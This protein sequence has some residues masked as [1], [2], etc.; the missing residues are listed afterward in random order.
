MKMMNGSYVEELKAVLSGKKV[1]IVGHD[2][3]DVDALLSSILMSRLLT[4]L[5][6]ENE[7][8]ILE[9][10]KKDDTYEIA[11]EMFGI[12]MEKWENVL[13]D[14][15]RTLFLLDHYT[16]I[17]KGTVIGCVDHHPNNA[18]KSYDFMYTRKACAAAYLVYE[19]MEEAGYCITAEEAK[20]IIVSMMVDT[21]AFRSSKTIETEAKKAKVLAEKFSL[22]YEELEKYCLCLTPVESM[23]IDQI[24]SNGQKWYDYSGNKVGS[25]Y[26][27][28]YGLPDEKVINSWIEALHVKRFESK[29]KMLVFIIF[30]TKDNT[31]HEYRITEEDTKHFVKLGIL[32]RGQD[33]MPLI[34]KK[35]SRK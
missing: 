29:S 31:T 17:H 9:K 18:D 24:I 4:F 8:A 27:Q 2:N 14:D 23:S 21:T 13:E 22:N 32:S 35:Y 16:T 12:K 3:I 10:V 11:E 28:L 33:I 20:M 1:T 30:E 7:F 34:E 26:L 25:A 15:T 19:I 5:G 6:I